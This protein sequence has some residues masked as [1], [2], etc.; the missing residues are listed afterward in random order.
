MVNLHF[1]DELSNDTSHTGETRQFINITPF[2]ITWE[3]WKCVCV[4]HYPP[5]TQKTTYLMQLSGSPS[6]SVLQRNRSHESHPIGGVLARPFSRACILLSVITPNTIKINGT[7]I[8][9]DFGGHCL[10]TNMMVFLYKTVSLYIEP[11]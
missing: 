5:K 4:P 11:T 1:W 2:N 3:P 7:F 6:Q 9:V 10:N 8:T